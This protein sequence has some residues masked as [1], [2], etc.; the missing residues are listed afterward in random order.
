MLDPRGQEKARDLPWLARRQITRQI[1]GDR[2]EHARSRPL[3]RLRV[4]L[5]YSVH[6]EQPEKNQIK[7]VYAGLDRM[8]QLSCN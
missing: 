8:R 4:F 1:R 7:L 5:S 6:R 2:H 3:A